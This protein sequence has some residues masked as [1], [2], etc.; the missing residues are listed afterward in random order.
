MKTEDLI[1]ARAISIGEYIV[2]N[3]ST[4]RQ[5]A[6]KFNVGRSTVFRDIHY[7]LPKINKSLAERVLSIIEKN[8]NERH[9]RGGNATKL[10]YLKI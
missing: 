10:K 2:L 6:K 4:I 7:R 5:A 9:I 8:K 1:I 3:N